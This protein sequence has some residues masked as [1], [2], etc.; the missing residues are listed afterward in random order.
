MLL[1]LIAFLYL[2]PPIIEPILSLLSIAEPVS[3][4]KLIPIFLLAIVI[5]L[6]PDV[7][8]GL[9][10][11]VFYKRW[12]YKKY[13]FTEKQAIPVD[14]IYLAKIKGQFACPLYVFYSIGGLSNVKKIFIN[15]E[16]ASDIIQAIREGTKAESEVIIIT[17]TFLPKFNN[18]VLFTNGTLKETNIVFN[19]ILSKRLQVVIRL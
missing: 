11:K 8:I 10:P 16:L 17:E 6:V 1:L 2:S 15:E 4:F 12:F 19:F 3:S 13:G 18:F 14:K 7:V 5:A 9:R